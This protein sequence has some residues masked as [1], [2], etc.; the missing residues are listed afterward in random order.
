MQMDARKCMEGRRANQDLGN[1]PMVA[2]G[3]K[4]IRGVG[5][6]IPTWYTDARVT[7]Y[8]RNLTTPCE[9]VPPS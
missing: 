2:V 8:M 1:K 7:Q 6:G 5:V 4:A 3:R 9:K